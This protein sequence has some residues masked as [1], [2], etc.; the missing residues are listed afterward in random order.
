ME[1]DRNSYSNIVKSISLFGGVK[2]VQIIV[3]VFLAKIIA[4]LVGT[5]GM[6][7]LNIFTSIIDTIFSVTGCG[8][9]TSAVR[10]V[11][12]AY[13]KADQSSINHT[14]SVLRILVLLT[15]ITGFILTF[16]FSIFLSFFLL[17]IETYSFLIKIF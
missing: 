17:V 8:L 5:S 12:R 14:I 13:S 9:Q 7:L 16:F 6:G 3:S 15:G 2:V 1:E 4:V 11:S 10:D